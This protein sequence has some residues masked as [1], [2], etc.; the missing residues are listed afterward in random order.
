MSVGEP[1]P[2]SAHTSWF[3]LERFAPYVGSWSRETFRRFLAVLLVG[4]LALTLILT[5]ALVALDR[6]EADTVVPAVLTGVFGLVG[7]A[8]G[9]Y[10]GRDETRVEPKEAEHSAVPDISL[11]ATVEPS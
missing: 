10:F 6:A 3:R 1:D 5:W 9:F 8:T 7:S 2:H 11:V 4:F